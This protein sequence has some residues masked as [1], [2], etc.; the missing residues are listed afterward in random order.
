MKKISFLVVSAALLAFCYPQVLRA[1]APA[2][3]DEKQSAQPA[4]RNGVFT[5]YALD[6][7]TRTFCFKD[8]K[9][10]MMFQ[11]NQWE[12]RCSDLSYSL[13]GGGSLVGGIEISRVASIVDL[14]TT[15]DLRERYAFEDAENGGLGFASLRL[16][17]NK[18][19]IAQGDL[20]N[21]TWQPLKENGQLFADGKSSAN[22]PIRLGHIYLVRISDIKDKSFQRIAK[23]IVIAYRPDEAVTFRWELLSK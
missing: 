5:M 1:Q 16:E 11:S 9:E 6:P 22:A 10:G 20:T 4:K 8:G 17:G 3:P 12:N 13:A 2:T 7:L 15:N 18:I 23:L 19:T 21:L 14:G